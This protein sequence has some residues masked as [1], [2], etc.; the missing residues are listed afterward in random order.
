M[1][2]MEDFAESVAA[3]L[4]PPAAQD[5]IAAKF[6]NRPEFAYTNYYEL[7][8]HSLSLRRFSTGGPRC[9]PERLCRKHVLRPV[10]T[11]AGPRSS[12]RF[13][14]RLL[15]IPSVSVPPCRDGGGPKRP[16][17]CP[18]PA[19]LLEWD[20]AGRHT[21]IGTHGAVYPWQSSGCLRLSSRTDGSE[22]DGIQPMW[23]EGAGPSWV[24][25]L[26]DKVADINLTF[27]ADVTVAD[28]V[29]RYGPP[30]V[31]SHGTAGL[32]EHPYY[33]LVMFY[34]TR[35]YNFYARPE[36]FREPVLDPN[37]KVKSA[38]YYVPYPS[39]QVRES[40][41]GLAVPRAPWPGYGALPRR[42]SPGG[43]Q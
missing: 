25:L 18:V 31:A 4:Y 41:P 43:P 42:V 21:V 37:T 8:G 12:P 23:G 7:P 36:S 20:H 11:L 24:V 19:T 29:T 17:G 2:A 9:D 14:V 40:R 32:P 10:K 35:G 30:E 16:D 39:L 33:L 38:V 13:C 15:G 26:D 28:I 3:F 34:P 6:G 22:V 27:W 1:N 5:Y